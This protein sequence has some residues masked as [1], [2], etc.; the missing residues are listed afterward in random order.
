MTV[1]DLQAHAFSHTLKKGFYEAVLRRRDSRNFLPNPIPPKILASILSAAHHAP[2]VG[3]MQPWNFMIIE[4]FYLRRRIQTHVNQ[5]R[6][7]AAKSFEKERREKYLAYKLEGILD[8][9]INICVTCDPTRAGPGVIGRNTIS[10]TDVY[11]TCCAIQNL[12][13][14]ARVEGIGVGW[15]SI[16]K[17]KTLRMI[18]GIPEHI[19][20]VAYLC[21]GYVYHFPDRPELEESGWRS[22]LPL[23]DLVFGDKWESS[24]PSDLLEVME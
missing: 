6:I 24:P 2:S 22:R 3:F 1:L 12:W 21:V 18:L 7:D 20:P 16:L 8:S 10:E 17:N 5:E 11:S 14:A 19:I 13:L 4:D 9:P 23:K 15:V